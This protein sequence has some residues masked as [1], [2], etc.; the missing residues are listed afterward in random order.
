MISPKVIVSQ[1]EVKLNIKYLRSVERVGKKWHY[2]SRRTQ[3]D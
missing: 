3:P 2:R 1:N